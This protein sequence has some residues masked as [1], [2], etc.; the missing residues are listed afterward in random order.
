MK[1]ATP[2][3][4]KGPYRQRKLGEALG[5]GFKGKKG[6]KMAWVHLVGLAAGRLQGQSSEPKPF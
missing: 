5:G 4:E 6:A 2:H 3:Q 1:Q